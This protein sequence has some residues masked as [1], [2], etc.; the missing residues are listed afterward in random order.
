MDCVYSLRGP[1]NYDV[2]YTLRMQLK[3]RLRDPFTN[4]RVFVSFSYR[5]IYCP[6]LVYTKITT[7]GDATTWKIIKI[8]ILIT[9]YNKRLLVP[10]R[11]E[12]HTRVGEHD[13]MFFGT[14]YS[15]INK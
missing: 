13:I 9:A 10:S 3:M 7:L 4:E 8:K 12:N 2:V 11:R 5:E 15:T 6:T 1:N 14:R